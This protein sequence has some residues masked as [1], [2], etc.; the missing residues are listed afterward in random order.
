MYNSI[1]NSI[2]QDHPSVKARKWVLNAKDICDKCR[3]QAL[4]KVKGASGELTFC[5]HHYDKIMNN[6]ES[7]KKMMAF[8]LEVIDE[9]EKLVRKKPIGGL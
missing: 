8:M 6:P 3:V 9:R 4:V 1:M 5:S 2:V 7:Y